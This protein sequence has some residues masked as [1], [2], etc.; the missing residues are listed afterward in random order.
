MR[1]SLPARDG[2]RYNRD[3][4][5]T[6]RS[7]LI[8]AL[9]VPDA[10]AAVASAERLA[11]K[12]GMFKVG[13][14]LFVAEGPSVVR[15][16]RERFPDTD[17][18]LDLKLHDIPNTMR[19]AIASARR[20]GARFITVHAGSGVEHLRACVEE[21]GDALGVL[22]VT[23]LTSQ[24]DQACKEAGHTRTAAELVELRAK[25]AAE[26][27][28]AGLVCSG[29]ELARVTAAAPSLFKVVPGIRPAGSAVG[30]QKRVMTPAMAIES[31]ATHLV[32]GRP[33]MKADD[34]T[35]SATAIVDEIAG[36]LTR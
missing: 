3:V 20:L 10:A 17:V 34:P 31:G 18:F 22:A 14:Q 27:G 6:A 5:D 29:Q 32:V 9:D 21:A 35:G 28:C 25:C 2:P 23:V 7:R 11:G 33:I 30:D 19:G 1:A 8:V 13:L 16:L 4:T 36:A 15:T 24:D 12:V 26:A